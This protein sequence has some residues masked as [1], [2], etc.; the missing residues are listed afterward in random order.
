MLSLQEEMR[1]SR[2]LLLPEIGREGQERLARARVLVIG[3]GGLGCPV[4]QYLAAAGVGT[5]GIADGDS[6]D[7]SN[8]QR[9]VLYTIADIDQPKAVVAK[10]KL[11]A[12]N[13][14]INIDVH[15]VFIDSIN[16]LE[17]IS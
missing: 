15:S 16:A 8:L 2:Q 12:L 11:K 7:I 9:Q 10:R 17:L 6:V 1:Y 4:L 14:H 3:A 13:P 5:I